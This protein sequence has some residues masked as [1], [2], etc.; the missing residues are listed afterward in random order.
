MRVKASV[1]TPK[2]KWGS[3]SHQSIG[4]VS[5]VI[6]SKQVRDQD[7]GVL[8]LFVEKSE[9]PEMCLV[10][11]SIVSDFFEEFY[12]LIRLSISIIINDFQVPV[13]NSICLLSP[14]YVSSDRK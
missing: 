7:P 13:L 14:K 1:T 11:Y 8:L 10:L 12:N 2:Y 5:E 6:P 4:V 3:V 9:I